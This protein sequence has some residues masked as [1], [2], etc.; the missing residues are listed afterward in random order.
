MRTQDAPL[1]QDSIGIADCL[2]KLAER[3]ELLRPGATYRVQFNRNFRFNDA[4]DLVPYL[5]ALGVTTLYASPIL[6]A[7]EGSVHGY[8]ITDHN[9]INPEIGTEEELRQLSSELQAHNMG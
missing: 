1:V 9:R 7:R 5:H 4:R 6:Q 3:K 8:D 2:Q